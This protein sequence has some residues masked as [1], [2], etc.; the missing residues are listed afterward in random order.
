[1]QL[2]PLKLLCGP[3]GGDDKPDDKRPIKKL[4][5]FDLEFQQFSFF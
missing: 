2:S 5:S 1:M 3:N 4:Q